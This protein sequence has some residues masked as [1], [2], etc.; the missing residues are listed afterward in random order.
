MAALGGLPLRMGDRGEEV[1]DLQQRLAGL[2]LD[3][4]DD[5][6]GRFGRHTAAAVCAFQEK[7]GLRA[8]GVCGDQTWAAVVEA[9]YRLGDRLV[10]LRQPMLRG[11]DVASLQRRLGALGFD[12]GRVDGIFGPHTQSALT[13]FQRNTGLVV[14]GV[15]GPATIQ[16]LERLGKRQDEREPVAVVRET[17]ALRQA[18]RT[19]D[20]MHVALGGQGVHAVLDA[21]ARTLVEAGAEVTLVQHPDQ[22]EQ[23]AE[24]N[25]C[26]VDVFLGLFLVAGR[27]ECSSAH[28]AGHRY[29]SAGGRRLAE[30][31]QDAVPS[32]LHVRD[33]GV[34]GMSLPILKETRMPAVLSEVGPPERVVAR[35]AVLASVLTRVL[36]DWAADP[37]DRPEGG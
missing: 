33:A 31:V 19:L 3:T 32:A 10:Y 23:A 17:E 20:A 2:S 8:D 9:G 34:R 26:G 21:T 36:S 27:E 30:L 14:D 1:R 6:A 24:A 29:E 22:S 18:S 37:C 7:R 11:D 28:Y 15:C 5:P 16:G 35:A 25:A 4:S 13:E 12:A